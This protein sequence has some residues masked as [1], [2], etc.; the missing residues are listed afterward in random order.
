MQDGSS[1]TYLCTP[2][3]FSA[4]GTPQTG[5]NPP[6]MPTL[7]APT[8]IPSTGPIAPQDIVGGLGIELPAYANDTVTAYFYLAGVD[9][10]TAKPVNNIVAVS[11][12]PTPQPLDQ[13]YAAGFGQPGTLQ[14]DYEAQGGTLQWS[15][16]AGPIT[17]NTTFKITS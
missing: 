4:I 7:D 11:Q 15:H 12:S 16:A 10:L 8:I 17:L 3:K 5:P 14:A 13:V 9:P 1:S 2:V 6:V